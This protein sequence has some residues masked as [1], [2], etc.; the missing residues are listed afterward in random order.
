MMT[1]LDRHRP[2]SALLIMAAIVSAS[3]ASLAQAPAPAATAATSDAKPQQVAINASPKVQPTPE[4]VGDALMAHQR[5]Q[6]AIEAYK[7]VPDP[8]AS[9][10]NKTGIAYQLMLNIQDAMRCY[11]ASL[12]LDPK[13][14]NVL[15]NLGTTYDAA[16]QYRT[17]EKLYR[18]ALKI[19]PRSALIHK[20]LGTNLL[21]QHKYERGWESY[22]AALAIDTTI[23]DHNTRPRVENPASVTERGAMNYYMAKGCARAGKPE[24]AIQY[25][26]AAINEGFTNPKKV[27]ADAEFASLH[28][29]PEFDA[30]VAQERAQQ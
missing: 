24:R 13:N 21:A 4:Q 11:Q 14:P 6:A 2:L 12:K 20:N 29:I 19:D 17:A 30:L 10:L 9:V 16:K 22:K 1:T 27:S 3:S 26:R 5:Y 28:G 8:D 23:F 15:N 18:K 7:K 25:L